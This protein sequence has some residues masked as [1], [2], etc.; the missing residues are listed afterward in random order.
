ME[1]PDNDWRMED[2]HYVAEDTRLSAGQIALRGSQV[3]RLS[4]AKIN[5]KKTI[6][7]LLPNS[8]ALF[9]NASRRAWLEAQE[10]RKASKIDRSIKKEVMFVTTRDSFDYLV[11]IKRTATLRKSISAGRSAVAL[12]PIG[13]GCHSTE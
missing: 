2:V 6:R 3:T 10:I 4:V 8:T 1:D 12:S 11:G 5:K 9:L 7:I 13:S